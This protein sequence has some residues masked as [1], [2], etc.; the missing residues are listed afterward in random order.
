MADEL[1][2]IALELIKG[3]YDLH[4]H[5]QPSHAQRT[6]DDFELVHEAAEAGMAGVMIKNHYEPT[7]A[8]AA[9]VNKY[10]GVA[11]T[12]LAYGG[13]T[14]NWPVGGLNPYAAASSLKL[15]GKIV[16]LPT[17]DSANSL[18]YGN[19]PGDFFDRPGI[20]LCD[21]Q[22]KLKD[23]VYEIMDVVKEYDAFLATGHL[24]LEETVLVCREGCKRNINMI[25]TH[26][27]WYRTI[28]PTELQV[29]LASMGVLVEKQRKPIAA[30]HVEKEEALRSFDLIG[31]ENIFMSTDSGIVGTAKPVEEMLLFIEML[32]AYGISEEKVKIMLRDNNRRIVRDL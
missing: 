26:P 28:V 31:C 13:V 10:A 15:G 19:M 1:R 24:N 4:T 5:P 17:R 32:L 27:D 18:V 2:T 11:D 25:L 21:D 30:G 6:L 7:E 14:L 22:G 12:T 8:R 9:L 3:G 23:S 16:W 20:S 29:E